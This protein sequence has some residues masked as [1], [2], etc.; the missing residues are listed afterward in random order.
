M[1][2]LI[3]NLSTFYR[4]EL[5][6]KPSELVKALNKEV[7]NSIEFFASQYIENPEDLDA[8]YDIFL[9]QGYL[10]L[11]KIL[12]Y[13]EILSVK[14]QSQS[15]KFIYEDCYANCIGVTKSVNSFHELKASEK[16]AKFNRLIDYSKIVSRQHALNVDL[17]VKANE[18]MEDILSDIR[19]QNV[20]IYNNYINQFIMSLVKITVILSQ[21]N[22]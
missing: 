2:A 17:A 19:K 7:D 8:K 9:S 14:D 5:S 11:N 6:K 21:L 4:T 22:N 3:P 12:S 18:Y 20:D 16:N 15:N 10:H 13:V 1:S